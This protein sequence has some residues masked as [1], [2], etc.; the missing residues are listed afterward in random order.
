M[1]STL[2]GAAVLIDVDGWV[3]ATQGIALQ[4]RL[5]V[6]GDGVPMVVPALGACT[7]EP[8]QGGYLLRS[9]G[10]MGSA[11]ASCRRPGSATTSTT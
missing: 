11:P 4:G 1:L 7:A 6:T 3:A 9:R 8:V 10:R 2:R 5:A